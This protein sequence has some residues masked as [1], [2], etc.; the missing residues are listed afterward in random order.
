MILNLVPMQLS[1]LYSVIYMYVYREDLLLLLL[2]RA[3]LAVE[4]SDFP[5]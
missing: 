2:L 3:A 1:Y 4:N 5:N